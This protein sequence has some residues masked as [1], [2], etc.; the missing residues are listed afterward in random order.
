[1]KPL[2]VCLPVVILLLPLQTL[3]FQVATH[4]RLLSKNTRLV[5]KERLLNP[6]SFQVAAGKRSDHYHKDSQHYD[7]D[8]YDDDNVE[9]EVPIGIP[10]LPAF[11]ASSFS[12]SHID[13]ST[14]MPSILTNN[15]ANTN[16]NPEDTTAFVSP[17]FKLQYT[18]NICE[19][20]NSHMVSRL[21]Y[22]EGVVIAICKGCKSKHL[23]ADNL[24]ETP[25]MNGGTNIEEYFK[26]KGM[27][28]VVNRVTPEVFALENILRFNSASGALVGEDG[29]PVLE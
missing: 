12:N 5:S 15:N 25:G 18:C 21:A 11:G 26:A 20:R 28:H 29:N 14:G 23:I 1:M 22:R 10:Q 9:L 24:N 13:F 6:R 4:H 8:D 17:K 19:T 3:A 16:T 7:D 27:E 2:S